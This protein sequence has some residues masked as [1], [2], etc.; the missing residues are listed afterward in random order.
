MPK[1]LQR[2]GYTDI[3][4]KAFFIGLVK[5]LKQFSYSPFH[6]GEIKTASKTHTL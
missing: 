4:Y 5:Y 1:T 2:Q 6:Y 3:V